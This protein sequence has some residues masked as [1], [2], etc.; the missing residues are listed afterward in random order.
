MRALVIVDMQNDFMPWGAAPAFQADRL[1]DTLRSL[2]EKFTHIYASQDWHPEEHISF[3]TNHGRR[4][5]EEIKTPYG[6]QLLWPVHCVQDSFGAEIVAPLQ[7]MPWKKILRK[8]NKPYVDTSSLF[9]DAEGKKASSLHQDLQKEGITDLY[10]A[11]VA[12]DLGIKNS[13]ID[14]AHLGYRCF[15]VEN[16]SA[17]SKENRHLH[18]RLLRMLQERGIKATF[19]SHC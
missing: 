3:A 19:S 10:F 16:A 2:A 5:Q 17:P 1:I 7:E 8:G 9:F 14:A 13:L 12:S 11:G 6:T 18:E 4:P 15:L